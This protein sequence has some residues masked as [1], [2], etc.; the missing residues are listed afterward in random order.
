MEDLQHFTRDLNQRFKGKMRFCLDRFLLADAYN[1]L[2][3]GD[4]FFKIYHAVDKTDAT[5][6]CNTLYDNTKSSVIIGLAH[7]ARQMYPAIAIVNY[8]DD[9]EHIVQSL[10]GALGK[11]YPML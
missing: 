2:K 11:Q 3:H 8:Y 6:H 1:N 5:D 7:R 9:M 4:A 10:Q